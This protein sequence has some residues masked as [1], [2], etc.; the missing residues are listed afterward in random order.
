MLIEGSAA[1]QFALDHGLDVGHQVCGDA[2]LR[3]GRVD[4]MAVSTD[5]ALSNQALGGLIANRA[6]QHRHV[7]DA[8]LLRAR[9]NIGQRAGPSSR[10]GEVILLGGRF[11]GW[12]TVS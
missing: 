3:G 2:S 10:T 5:V 1:A 6:L 7:A 9:G 8:H 4:G 11:A 12:L